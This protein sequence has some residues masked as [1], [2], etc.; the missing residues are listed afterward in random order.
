MMRQTLSWF[1]PPFVSKSLTTDTL[2]VPTGRVPAPTQG[3]Q[4]GQQ[5]P[6]VMLALTAPELAVWGD[7]LQRGGQRAAVGTGP[8]GK[9]AASVENAE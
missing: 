7:A 4:S 5:P 6:C 3:G 1:R 8:R 2:T 9:V